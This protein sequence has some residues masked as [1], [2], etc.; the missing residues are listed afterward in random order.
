MQRAKSCISAFFR[1]VK[2]RPNLLSSLH[3]PMHPREG[4]LL[5]FFS[6]SWRLDYTGKD[7]EGRGRDMEKAK[8]RSNISLTM[9][10]KIIAYRILFFYKFQ[11]LFCFP[12]FVLL[13]FCRE[14]LVSIR[15]THSLRTSAKLSGTKWALYHD[16]PQT[17]LVNKSF[18]F[19]H[20][21][22]FLYLP[23][24]AQM[25]ENCFSAVWEEIPPHILSLSLPSE[26]PSL[27]GKARSHTW[28]PP[29][30]QPRGQ[31]FGH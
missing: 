2:S 27:C 26:A 18:S 4:S 5:C 14:C 3:P 13:Q 19:H 6:S 30:K 10:K 29:K 17:R 28:A 22:N 11:I 21:S 9:V 8:P 24:R 16:F 15:I 25:S 1:F 7:G 31:N 12:N 20:T 23:P